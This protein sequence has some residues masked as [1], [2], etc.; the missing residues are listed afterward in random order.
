MK[1]RI[2]LLFVMSLMVLNLAKAA[3]IKV[4]SGVANALKT[5]V[6]SAVVGDVILLEYNGV[7]FF[8]GTISIDTSITFKAYEK[9]DGDAAT[10]PLPYIAPLADAEGGYTSTMIEIYDDF[11]MENIEMR[12]TLP[13]TDNANIRRALR[14]RADGV[15]LKLNGCVIS[16]FWYS[17]IRT[18]NRTE[19][20]EVIDCKFLADRHYTQ[21]DNGRFLELR[22]KGSDKIVVQNTTI[23]NSTSMWI[24]HESWADYADVPTIDILVI[25]HCTF[26]HQMGQQPA[27]DIRDVVDL[28][29]TN[30]IVANPMMLGS[31]EYSGRIPAWDMSW[32]DENR[33]TTVGPDKMVIFS[34]YNVAANN[35]TAKFS[36][37]NVYLEADSKAA[38]LVDNTNDRSSEADL[39]TY[40]FLNVINADEATFAEELTFGRAPAT[41]NAMVTEFVAKVDTVSESNHNSEDNWLAEITNTME[42]LGYRDP[43]L[44]DVDLSY[45]DDSKSYYSAEGGY[46]LGDLNY[47]P[48]MKTAWENGE[49]VEYTLTTSIVGGGSSTIELDPAGGFYVAGTQVSATVILDDESTFI[50]WSGDAS[51]T[52]TTVV[53]TIDGNKDIVANVNYTSINDNQYD[54]FNLSSYPN[55]FSTN[56]A[57]K[58]SVENSS[59]VKLAVF[60]ITGSLVNVLINENQVKGEYSVNWNG[61]NFSGN[62]V[63]S[64]IYFAKLQM[65]DG[66]SS[67]IKLIISK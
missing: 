48:E 58:Y 50:N 44:D 12:G 28:T 54:N 13:G 34:I 5:A 14:V 9:I 7:Y 1:K 25:D 59:S 22:G 65:T 47:F 23:A 20:I 35:T 37:N 6:E 30:N 31:D 63:S 42:L 55:P 3:D 21:V 11:T 36:N 32:L 27:M 2:T 26:I 15:Q 40:D 8:D 19:L 43:V 66:S 4:E 57:I 49:A 10:M 24:H 46:P 38:L 64:G 56:V 52:E 33:V 17:S 51:G 61:E 16:D 62:K 18:D 60:D 39:F 53:I 45:N 29:F 67:T 41:P